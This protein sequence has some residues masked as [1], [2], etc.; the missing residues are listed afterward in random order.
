MTDDTRR[1][2]TAAEYE[3]ISGHIQLDLNDPRIDRVKLKLRKNGAGLSDDDEQTAIRSGA[4]CFLSIVVRADPMPDREIDRI[5]RSV[6]AEISVD[7]QLGSP[8][9]ESA[10]SVIALCRAL[11]QAKAMI[12]RESYFASLKGA[13]KW[14]A[15]RLREILVDGKPLPSVLKYNVSVRTHGADEAQDGEDE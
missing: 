13:K 15:Y 4:P 2:I 7:Q 9:Q 11:R 6:E 12:P 1:H 14:V 3:A 10:I 8:I 5:L